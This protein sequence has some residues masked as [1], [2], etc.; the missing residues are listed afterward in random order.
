[1]EGSLFFLILQLTLPPLP[2]GLAGPFFKATL[3]NHKS[4]GAVKSPGSISNSVVGE[5][6]KFTVMLPLPL[7]GGG[8]G[9]GELKDM[10]AFQE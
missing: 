7:T 6:E 1:M 8:K 10:I 9:E 2:F 4:E 3:L 5:K